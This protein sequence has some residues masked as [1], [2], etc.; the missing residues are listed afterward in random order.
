MCSMGSS[1]GP[2]LMS[3]SR[4]PAR[5]FCSR[6]WPAHRKAVLETWFTP[7]VRVNTWRAEPTPRVEMQGMERPQIEARC[8]HASRDTSC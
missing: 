3:W 4:M 8:G 5:A 2:V 6:A 7:R 1:A